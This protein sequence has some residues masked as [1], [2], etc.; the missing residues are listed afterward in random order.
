MTAV[1]LITAKGVSKGL[2]GKNKK[3]MLGEPL[4]YWSIQAALDAESVQQ[5]IVSSDDDE[6]LALAEY[7]GAQSL[8]RPDALCR[9]S[10]PSDAV[11][12]HAIK[13]HPDCSCADICLL[14]PTSPLRTAKHI[15]EAYAMFHS[16]SCHAVIGVVKPPYNAAKAYKINADGSIQGLLSKDAP[17]QPRQQLP[18]NCFPNGAIYWFNATQF[19]KTSSIPRDVIFPYEMSLQD[20]I[21]IDD[22][23][24][25]NRA[26]ALLEERMLLEQS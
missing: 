26:T 1:A 5:V 17:Y 20:S 2:P 22:L 3:I 9:D 21:D 16:R 14:Q 23:D 10:T 11:I 8:R 18:E 13:T 19:L 25:F 4:I 15:D 12:E 6:I 24:D 7:Y